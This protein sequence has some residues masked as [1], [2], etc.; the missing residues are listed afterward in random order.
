MEKLRKIV[1]WLLVV[2]LTLGGLVSSVASLE[3]ASAQD[4]LSFEAGTYTGVADGFGGSVEAI[5]TVTDTSIESIQVIAEGETGEIGTAA[6]SEIT[7]A[8]LQT[9]SLAIDVV[10]GATVS[11][12]AVLAAIEDALTQAGAD[13][14][15]LKDETNKLSVERVEQE[16]FE[17]DVVVIGAGGAGM[18]AA[19]EAALA[20]K[21]VVI[22]EQQAVIGGNTNRATGGMN[23]SETYIQAEL[24]VED[25]N[26]Q[27]YEDTFK[28][29]YELN[30]PELLRTMVEQSAD[31]LQWVNDLGAD[32]T[33]VSFS[34]GQTNARI[35]KSKDG[36]AVG[37]VLVGVLKEKLDELNVPIYLESEARVLITNEEGHVVGVMVVQP[38]GSNFIVYADAVILATG[39]FGAN[40]EMVEQY[41]PT[42]VGFETTN[43]PG[44]TG[45]GIQMAVEVG[46]DLYQME[47][48]QIHPTTQPGT[49]YLYTEG[50]RGDGAILINKEGQRFT[51]ELL[52][53]DV[54]SANIIAQTDSVAYLIVN[55]ELVDQN[56]S[57]ASYIEK[58]HAVKGDSLEELAAALSVD[59]DA[60]QAT[61]DTYNVAQ[62][63]GVDEAFGRANMTMS[64]ANGPYYALAV[65]P[66]IHH[67]MGGLKID[68]D[69]HVLNTDGEII[70][71]LFAA[72]EVVGGVHGG[73]RIGG[74]AVLDIIVFGRIAGQMAATDLEAVL[75]EGTEEE[76]S[77][78]DESEEL[79]SEDESESSEESDIDDSSEQEETNSDENSSS[80]EETAS[81]DESSHSEDESSDEASGESD[82]EASSDKESSSEPEPEDDAA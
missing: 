64:L 7:E 24:G 5:V 4:G 2:G 33:D 28:G 1:G 73:N 26:E 23:A 9:Q 38:D 61:L 50:L 65:T 76:S 34:G 18:A 17:T 56:A 72:G 67:T 27:F 36:S 57:M 14:A 42:K 25:S 35:H 74:N 22:L 45:S 78:E 55:Q 69:T 44:A 43:H 68:A 39:G 79:S 30:D 6:I 46:A 75:E 66:S 54:V 60:L 29:G 62:A 10:S 59:A 48:I 71:G 53:R 19:I 12:T 49:G 21:D 77:E 40:L 16:D 52:T 70:P 58:G 51:D 80:S 15:Y 41:D 32:L 82:S 8:I 3:T 81:G 13:L 20:G 11:S 47:E 37:P 63:S 31:A